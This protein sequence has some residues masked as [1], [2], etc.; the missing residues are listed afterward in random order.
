MAPRTKKPK[1]YGVRKQ[2][3]F[4]CE[5]AL[6]ND[7]DVS[8]ILPDHPLYEGG[9]TVSQFLLQH[10]LTRC[11]APAIKAAAQQEAQAK[12]TE[13][14]GTTGPEAV[15]EPIDANPANNETDVVGTAD[16]EIETELVAC[17]DPPATE[18]PRKRGH[19]ETEAPLTRPF[20][21]PKAREPKKVMTIAA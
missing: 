4:L 14:E 18:P 17:P 21:K 8:K 3:K 7:G 9:P 16:G 13:Q 19:K 1:T 20:K 6:S 11:I 10:Y 12:S 15:P 2:W 5:Y